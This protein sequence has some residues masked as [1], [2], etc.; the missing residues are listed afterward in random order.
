MTNS[1]V[2]KPIGL[3]ALLGLVPLAA[4]MGTTTASAATDS[5]VKPTVV[6][7]HL[8]AN[9]KTLIG[10]LGGCTLA[11]TGGTGKLSSFVP[12]GGTVAWANGTTTTYTSTPTYSG[13]LCP[14]STH[15]FNIKGS[16]TSSTNLTIPVG[17]PIKMTV[18]LT[19]NTK[20][21]NAAHT[22]VTF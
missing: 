3:V 1:R 9:P 8:R 16:V 11:A 21:V 17:A 4:M 7:K 14:A 18:C 15:E 5:S 13:S 10:A 22:R 20:V 2:P 12:N 6:C 19:G